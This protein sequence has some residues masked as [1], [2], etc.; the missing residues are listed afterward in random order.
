MCPTAR[1]RQMVA[2]AHGFRVGAA[3]CSHLERGGFNA[4]PLL[5][6]GEIRR[7]W[8]SFGSRLESLAPWW[9][10]SGYQRLRID[11]TVA[12]GVRN[13]T[14]AMGGGLFVSV[15]RTPE[16]LEGL[17]AEQLFR[18]VVTTAAALAAKRAKIQPPDLEEPFRTHD[19]QGCS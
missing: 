17:D 13:S 2:S 4:Y 19:R 14:N 15:G 11:V 6:P 12:P 3:P 1:P 5:V 18:E 16:S 10:T 9:A 7:V 8:S